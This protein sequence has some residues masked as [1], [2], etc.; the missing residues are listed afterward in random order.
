[1]NANVINRIRTVSST[2]VYC[3]SH[4]SGVAL[5]SQVRLLAQAAIFQQLYWMDCHEFFVQ[6][7]MA[8]KRM[9]HNDFGD[10]LI[11]NLALS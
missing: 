6:P 7:F 10:R 2:A 4:A 3:F 1:M 11:F 8:P 9:N 5:K